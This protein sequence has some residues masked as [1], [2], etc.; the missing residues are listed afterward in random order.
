VSS[1]PKTVII[2][3]GI[4]GLSAAYYLAQSGI[5]ATVIE[6]RP[7][8]GGVISTEVID[9]CVVEGGPDSFLA[10]KLEALELIRE[11]GLGQ[12][13]IDSNDE[14]RVVYIVRNGRLVP[15]P[16]GLLMMVPT[17]VMPILTSPLLGWSTKLRMGLEYFR[18]RHAANGRD[19]SVADFVADHYGREAVDYLA[20]P[21]LAGVYGG[22]PDRLSV[23]AT[24]PRLVAIERKHGSLTR[25][26]L[27][28][29]KRSSGSLFKTLKRGLGS[30]VDALRPHVPE[31]IH[32]EAEA[33]GAGCVRVDGQWM[34]A[35]Q[36]VL[37]CPAHETA[38]LIGELDPL[39]VQ[40][41]ST[42][43]HASSI[44]A[45]FGYRRTELQHPLN[46]FGFLVPRRERG[47]LM[48]CTWV[49]SKFAHRVTGD[50]ALLR[51]FLTGTSFD[52]EAVR[53]DLSRF[54]GVKAE[55]VFVSVS[56]WPQALAQ[57]T[58]GHAGRL[59]RIESR[60]AAYP[61]LHLIGNS[62]HGI[63][64]PDCIRLAKRAAERIAASQR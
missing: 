58:V 40:E 5:A 6:R 47:V 27:S 36:V 61:F 32:G 35:G 41:L 12:E 45:A 63:G 29:P 14:Q 57:Y 7:R 28:E 52:Q 46:G 16:D 23:E 8:L 38:R 37:A 19:R 3:G 26:V 34:A 59:D 33:V 21:L 24:M 31:V 17:R 20:E 22:S 64:I 10:S 50:M 44:T 39:L 30:L 55:P 9:G 11:L 49:G 1:N 62:Y 48:A 13:V 25:G 51:C 43:E 18:S 4:S 53:A 56:R 60:A 15:M 42:I 54:M 2:G